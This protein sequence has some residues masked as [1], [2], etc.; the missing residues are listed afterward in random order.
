VTNKER[1]H[2]AL[3]GRPVDRFP[4]TVLYG[5][6]YHMDRF[7][8]LTDLPQWRV[9]EWVSSG[10]ERHV[11]LLRIMQERA[12]FETIMPVHGGAS[13]SWRER[14]EFVERDGRPYR[15]DLATG[16]WFPIHLDPSGHPFGQ[17]A[18]ETRHVVT[19]EDVDRRV[20]PEDIDAVIADGRNDN[21][22]AIVRAFPDDFII[23]GGVVG[24]VFNCTYHVGLTNF[25]AL[26][27]EEPEFIDYLCEKTLAQEISRI[28]RFARAGG[29]AVFID[30]SLASSDMISPTHYERHSVP[31][32]RAMVDEIHRL[33]HKAFLAHWGGISDRLDQVA[34]TGADGLLMECSM[35][36]YVNDVATVIERIGD[37]MTVC[38]NID[39]V[40]ILQDGTDEEL[41]AEVRRQVAAGRRGRGFIITIASPIT[42]RTPLRRVQRFLELGRRIGV[43]E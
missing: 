19:R 41:E 14:H 42:P 30:D 1:V 12:P 13:R 33:G 24:T 23:S 10:P 22:D 35:K 11:E 2:A 25:L 27:V 40:G 5:L 16:E 15:H 20:Q 4:V 6:Y 36:G 32:V 34:S 18:D 17:T 7:A 39:P 29:D 3:E 9:H 21:V 28:R 43:C 26:L 38:A 8:E 31:Y 37:R